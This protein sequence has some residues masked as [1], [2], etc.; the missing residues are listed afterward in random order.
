MRRSGAGANPF[1]NIE[2]KTLVRMACSSGN[3]VVDEGAAEI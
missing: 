3:A 2:I 1:L